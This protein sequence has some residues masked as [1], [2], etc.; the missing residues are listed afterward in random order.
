MA[1]ESIPRLVP[2]HFFSPSPSSWKASTRPSLPPSL[3]FY[4]SRDAL[5]RI[6]VAVTI[7]S[8][9]A[10]RPPFSNCVNVDQIIGLLLNGYVADIFGYRQAMVACLFCMV[11]FIFLQFFATNIWM[12]LGSGLLLGIPWGAFQ[13]IATTYAA[14]VCP[15]VLR[16]Y[17]TMTVSLCW[18]IG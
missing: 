18:S 6:W 1:S 7:R 8:A 17:L 14:E 2:S 4:P 10:S 11:C 5:A 3:P 15:S 9:P 16:S 13:T 12:Y